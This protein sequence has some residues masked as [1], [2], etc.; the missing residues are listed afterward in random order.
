MKLFEDRLAIGL[1]TVALAW[2]LSAC[3]SSLKNAADSGSGG[4]AGAAGGISVGPAGGTVNQD[5]VTLVIPPGAL[6]GDTTI[7]ISTTAAPAGYTVASAA[8]Q[9][10]PAGTTFYQPVTVTI[11][12]TAPAP[13]VHLFWSNAD[14]D[15]DDLGGTVSG[16][17]LSGRVMHFSVG[18]AG[19][20]AVDGGA[21][22]DSAVDS[23]HADVA[24][25]DAGASDA[26]PAEAATS[27][28]SGS[29]FDSSDAVDAAVDAAV[30]AVVDS[31]VEAS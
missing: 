31:A 1:G 15:Y 23:P 28:D 5:G 6:A 3:S 11:P 22:T 27:V 18:F 30:E 14:G 29:P 9:F 2:A 20:L 8:Y 21:I 7:A 12:L 25:T 16:T 10:A 4:S 19:T 13:G 24:V 17:T 26:S